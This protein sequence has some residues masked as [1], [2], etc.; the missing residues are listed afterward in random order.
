M[1]K[2]TLSSYLEVKNANDPLS[3]DVFVVMFCQR[4]VC[5]SEPWLTSSLLPPQ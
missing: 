1:A 4:Q 3:T 5:L 2:L